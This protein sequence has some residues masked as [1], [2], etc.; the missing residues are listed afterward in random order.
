MPFPVAIKQQPE[1][2]QTTLN[3]SA[4]NLPQMAQNQL[5]GI[6]NGLILNWP[7]PQMV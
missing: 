1:D 5:T 3:L 4:L 6:A 7:K 2:T